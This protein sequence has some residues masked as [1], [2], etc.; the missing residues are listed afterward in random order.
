M[1]GSGGAPPPQVVLSMT[2]IRGVVEEVREGLLHCLNSSPN[3]WLTFR[4][5]TSLGIG[6]EETDPRPPPPK[7]R[8]PHFLMTADFGS[9]EQDHGIARQACRRDGQCFRD[10]K[11]KQP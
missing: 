4:D 1:E 7:E 6:P 11:E 9:D 5:A 2:I 8:S 3:Q 10:S